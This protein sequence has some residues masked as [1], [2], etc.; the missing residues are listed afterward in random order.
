MSIHNGPAHVS[1]PVPRPVELFAT[2]GLALSTLIAVTAVSIG[3]ARADMLIM[4]ASSDTGGFALA[5]F[6]S[7]LFALMGGLTILMARERSR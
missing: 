6:T 7:P 1:R 4:H 3:I 2:L 5:L